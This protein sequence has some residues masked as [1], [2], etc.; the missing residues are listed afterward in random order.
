VTVFEW[1]PNDP[2][3]SARAPHEVAGIL[4]WHQAKVP[5]QKIMELL[6]MRGTQLIKD[7]EVAKSKA[8]TARALSIPVH[9]ALIIQD[10]S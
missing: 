1:D 4:R 7:M 2:V 3:L 8:D 10:N 6:K 5:S 9:D